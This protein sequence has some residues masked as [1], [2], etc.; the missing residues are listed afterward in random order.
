MIIYRTKDGDTLDQICWK[1]YGRTSGIVEQ[2]LSANRHL[3]EAD[4]VL[5][6]GIQITLPE[7][8]TQ[9]Q[10]NAVRLWD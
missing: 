2:V 3:E 5:V 8:N 4:A 10:E 1:H 9:R 6:A 7:I